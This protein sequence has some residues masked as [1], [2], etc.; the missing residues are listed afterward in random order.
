M[1]S[2]FKDEEMLGGKIPIP[3]SN[4]VDAKNMRVAAI[5]AILA[6]SVDRNIFQPTYHLGPNSGLRELFVQQATKNSRRESWCRALLLPMFP[7]YQEAVAADRCAKVVHEVM[8]IVQGLLPGEQID[9]FRIRL[10]QFT[11][12]AIDAWKR[13]QR[14]K[15]KLE[16]DFDMTVYE[17]MRWQALKLDGGTVSNGEGAEVNGIED[18]SEVRLVVFPRLY[19]VDDTKT[20]PVTTGVVLKKSQC[21]GAQREMDD[22]QP[23]SPVIGR[24]LDAGARRRFSRNDGVALNGPTTQGKTFLG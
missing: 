18:T 2:G 5:L 3:Q 24:P 9:R 12:S 4:T 16:S 21:E 22:T 15:E 8:S 20:V 19:V 1:W 6:R 14:I 17:E 13:I 11:E 7:Q 10:N 23:G